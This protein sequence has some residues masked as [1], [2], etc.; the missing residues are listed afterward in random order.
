MRVINRLLT[1]LI[2]SF[3][4]SLLYFICFVWLWLPHVDDSAHCALCLFPSLCRRGLSW[5]QVSRRTTW[6]RCWTLRGYAELRRPDGTKAE[7]PPPLCAVFF[8][9][10]ERNRDLFF[11]RKKENTDCDWNQT[12]ASSP[13]TL[14]GNIWRERE[15]ERW[16]S[17]LRS[18]KEKLNII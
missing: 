1:G 12:H 13:L 3:W 11:S 7:T 4:S 5:S 14:S 15:R 17:L 9:L 8:F 2:V 16:S 18:R 10:N 6:R